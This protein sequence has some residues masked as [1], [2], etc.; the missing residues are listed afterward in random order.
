MPENETIVSASPTQDTSAIVTEAQ[1][2][3]PQF[4]MDEYV[5]SNMEQR[6]NPKSI[7]NNEQQQDNNGQSNVV[8][9][10]PVLIPI[11]TFKEYGF[12]SQDSIVEAI[13]EYKTLKSAPL[14]QPEPIKFENEESEKLFRA[15]QGGKKDEVYNYL[16]E[17]KKLEQYASADVD[18]KTADDILKLDMQVKYK[19]ADV[20]LSTEDINRLFNR[21][22]N[23][24]KEPI[25]SDLEDD[26]EFATRKTA[27]QEQVNDIVAQKI[28]DAKIAKPNIIAAKANLKFPELNNTADEGYIQ[29]QENLKLGEQIEAEDK[30]AY[31]LFAPKSIEVKTNYIDEKN[32]VKVDFRYEPDTES[33]NQAKEMAS[34]VNLLFKSFIGQ[35]GKPDREAF[36]EFIY[37]GKNI[38]KVITEAIKQAKTETII[39]K[40]PDNT[41]G[42]FNRQ[43]AQSQQVSQFDE[44]MRQA[45]ALWPGQQKSRVS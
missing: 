5:R 40:L 13:K 3:Q 28:L 43:P 26:T 41:Q 44:Q 27:W 1:D 31:K 32:G 15:W 20:N 33:F 14:P 7:E 19:K 10:Q 22:Y 17:Q 24:P 2:T 4:N 23:I 25:Q 34:D 9:P 18:E 36:L 45:F 35:D 11:D 29:Y 21:Q 12:E 39:S 16:A 8:A 30:E 6:F 38:Q 42:S 37:Y